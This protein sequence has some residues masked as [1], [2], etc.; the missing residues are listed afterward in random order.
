MNTVTIEVDERVAAL[1]RRPDQSATE[2]AREVIVTEL[3]RRGELSRGKAAELLDLSL[4]EFLRHTSRLGIAYADYT[5][6]EW[7][8]EQDSIKDIAATVPRSATPA[9]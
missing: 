1:L 6:D 2:A 9:R 3:Y 8:A 7:A 4:E 5:E